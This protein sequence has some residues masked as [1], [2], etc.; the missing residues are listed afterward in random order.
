[1]ATASQPRHY[2]AP[3]FDGT[4]IVLESIFQARFV[5]L[6]HFALA[7]RSDRCLAPRMV[8][9]VPIMRSKAACR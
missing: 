9:I 5:P 8:S 1:M 7:I 6:T 2:G 3:L 4:S